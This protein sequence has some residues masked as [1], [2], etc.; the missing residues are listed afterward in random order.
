[1]A[2]KNDSENHSQWDLGWVLFSLALVVLDVVWVIT[3]APL[4]F[5]WTGVLGVLIFAG[6]FLS[7]A[8]R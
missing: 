4:K 6:L 7:R 3:R 2:D 8:R 1:M 5:S